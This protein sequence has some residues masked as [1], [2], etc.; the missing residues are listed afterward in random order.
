MLIFKGLFV[1]L[2]C[3][4]PKYGC[5]AQP[6]LGLTIYLYCGFWVF[7][8]GWSFTRMPKHTPVSS[9]LSLYFTESLP[10]FLRTTTLFSHHS[11][12]NCPPIIRYEGV[13]HPKSCNYV[14]SHELFN[15]YVLDISQCLSLH[16]FSKVIHSYQNKSPI[17]C[18]LGKG[19]RMSSPHCAKGQGLLTGFKQPTGWWINRACF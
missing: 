1:N 7:Y 11:L 5:W 18:G 8:W 19:P 3:A 17:A 12:Q 9:N 6:L 16:P 13:W 4:Y 10:F 15:I 2:R 14:P